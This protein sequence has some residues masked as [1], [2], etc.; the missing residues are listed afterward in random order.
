MSVKDLIQQFKSFDPNCKVYVADEWGGYIEMEKTF[1]SEVQIA[2]NDHLKAYEQVV[3]GSTR[4]NKR[5]KGIT[6]G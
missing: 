1:T 3:E 4:W 6:I 2:F 5:E